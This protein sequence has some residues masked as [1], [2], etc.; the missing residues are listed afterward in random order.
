MAA[1]ATVLSPGTWFW[2]E[3]IKW[4]SETLR[5]LPSMTVSTPVAITMSA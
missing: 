3:H 2:A 4:L 5:T 1:W